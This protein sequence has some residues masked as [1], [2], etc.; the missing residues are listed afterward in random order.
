[1]KTAQVAFVALIN[2][3]QDEAFYSNIY[4]VQYAALFLVT[5]THTHTHT[6]H[7]RMSPLGPGPALTGSGSLLR[8][9]VFPPTALFSTSSDR[10]GVL[11]FFLGGI[12]RS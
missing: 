2:V 12:I 4:L 9:T 10:V 7:K 8:S 1:M 11:F 3:F 5:S 6:L